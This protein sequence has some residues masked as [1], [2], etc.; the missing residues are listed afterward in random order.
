L[1]RAAAACGVV[2]GPAFVTVFTALGRRRAGYDWRRHAVSALAIGPEGWRQQLNFVAAGGLYCAAGRGLARRSRRASG[3]SVVPGLVTGAG[4]GLI[5]SGL[6]VTDPVA[7]FRAPGPARPTHEPTLH[8][9]LH[10]LSA[11]PVFL[12]IP[13][14]AL[15]STASAA[16][17]RKLGW[18]A[19]SLGSAAAMAGTTV[20]FGKAFAGS[21]RLRGR[22]GLFQRLSIV[23]AL[24][25]LSALCARSLTYT[26]DVGATR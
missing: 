3:P 5:G 24:Q 21:P 11:I 9:Q 6:F 23:A 10:N 15:L 7:G 22:G 20:L 19:Y 8:G 26:P 1:S 4:V 13:A 16:G 25:W 17:Q 12:G 2:A 18:A 14:A